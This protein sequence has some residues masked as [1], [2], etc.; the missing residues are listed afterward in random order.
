VWHEVKVIALKPGVTLDTI[1]RL[2]RAGTGWRQLT[3]PTSGI[4]TAAPGMTTP[5]RLLVDLAGGRTYVLVCGFQD[6]DSTPRHSR[7][8]MVRAIYVR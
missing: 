5:G 3:E 1:V 8:G 2:E 4:L 7:L 6:S